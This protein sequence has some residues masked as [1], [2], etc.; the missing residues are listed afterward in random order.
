M[1]VTT[2]TIK[3][4]TRG[5][6]DIIDITPDVR[7]NLRDTNLQN[8]VVT[9]FCPGSTGGMTTVEYEPGLVRDVK[10]FFEE[11]AP[12]GKIYQHNLSHGDGN[13][14]AHVCATLL[15]PS[16]SVP[17]VNGELTLG[18]WQQ[19]IFIDFDTRPRRRELV[20]QVVG[21]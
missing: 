12:Q 16:L 1:P 6:N 5:N 3:L 10:D 19:I 7:K 18:V 14:H 9:V 20:M 4:S 15:G 17:F 13:G 11:I 21:E 8:G 2:K